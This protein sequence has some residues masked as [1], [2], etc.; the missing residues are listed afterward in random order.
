MPRFERAEHILEAAV[1]WRDRCLLKEGSVLSG[2]RLWT[3]ENVQELV[4][5]YVANPDEGEGSFFQKLKGQLKPAA[6]AVNQLAAEMFWVMYLVVAQGAMGGETKRSQIRDVWSWSGEALEDEVAALGLPMDDGVA[7]PGTA[8]HTHRWREFRFFV[9]LLAQWLDLPLEARRNLLKEPWAYAAWIDGCE[10]VEGRQLRHALVF[11]LFPDEFEPIVSRS[12]KRD[13]CAAYEKK[14]GEDSKT[15]LKNAFEV[16]RALLQIRQRLESEAD[17][18]QPVQFYREPYASVW[19]TGNSSVSEKKGKEE[20]EPATE[21]DLEGARA[22]FS[23]RFGEASVWMLSAGEGGRLWEDF[24]YSGLISINWKLGDLTQYESRAAMGDALGGGNPYND[25][26]A[27]WQF[28]HEMKPG[29]VVIAKQGRTRLLG[30]G[31]ITGDYEFDEDRPEGPNIRSVDWRWRKGLQVPKARSF[32]V[33]TLTNFTRDPY[34]VWVRDVFGW[35]EADGSEK[36][37]PSPLPPPY[38]LGEALEDVF[39]SSAEF[40]Q[41]LDSIN[42]RKNLIL[43]GPPGVGKTFIAKRVAWSVIGSKVDD[44]I[45]MVQFHQSYS[46][47]DF[48]QGWRPTESGGFVLRDGVFLRF[49]D[50]ARK[51][52]DRRH[53]FI[54]DEINRG[55]LSKIFGELLMLIESD[56][57]GDAFSIPLTYAQGEERFSVPENVYILGMMNTADKSLSLV[58]YALRRRFAFSSLRPSFNSDG[59]EAYLASMGVE[60]DLIRR[61]IEKMSS[62]NETIRGDDKELGPGF[63]IGHSYFVPPEDQDAIDEEWYARVVRTQ[64][65]P[66]LAEYWFDQ[67]QKA[68][69]LVEE[70]LA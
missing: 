23:K 40:V 49:C 2:K 24:Q 41:I 30:W 68:L 67:P 11:L 13:I 25:T 18:G 33:K 27:L 65:Q 19:K 9:T 47:E 50:K 6:P 60:A 20:S 12:N 62:L 52:P 1:E 69:D 29:D 4:R 7:N 54:I 10:G 51:R 53:V 43:Q 36:P 57:R 55:N 39:L 5:D 42:L 31:V 70:L 17:P 8:Y 44:C 46:Y 16:D 26:L 32:A 38:E 3:R 64:I 66:L 63:E 58:D 15:D 59:F 14:W 48:V 61:I 56:K 21:A 28:A 34:K 45:E 22:W 35:M 37:D